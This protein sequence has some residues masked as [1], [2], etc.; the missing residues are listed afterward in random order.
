MARVHNRSRLLAWIGAGVVLLSAAGWAISVFGGRGAVYTMV[1]EPEP[2]KGSPDWFELRTRAWRAWLLDHR[3]AVG[4]TGYT[5]VH[6]DADRLRQQWRA[7]AG[8]KFYVSGGSTIQSWNSWRKGDRRLLGAGYQHDHGG[9][10][11]I[12]H[13]ILHVPCWLPLTIGLMPIVWHV[14]PANRRARRRA[15]GLC[16]RCGYD[17]AGVSPSTQCPECGAAAPQIDGSTRASRA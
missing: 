12:W 7:E 3:L 4:G 6:R 8:W 2:S 14:L 17:R 9:G 13:A 15:A 1:G 5:S 10:T 11:G 16:E